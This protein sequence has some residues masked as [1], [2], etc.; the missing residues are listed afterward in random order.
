MET[1]PTGSKPAQSLAAND[2]AR[3]IARRVEEASVLLKKAQAEIAKEVFGQDDT[4]KT[5]L[6]CLVAGGHMLAEGVPGV[7]KTL[8]VSAMSKVIGIQFG[9]IQFTSDLMPGDIIGTELGRKDSAGNSY[10]EFVKGPLFCSFLLGDEINRA[11]PK[12]QSALLEAMQEK[13]VTTAGVT[14]R[15]PKPFHVMATQNPEDQEGTNPLPEAQIDRFMVCMDVDY[16]DEAASRRIIQDN[17][18]D[19][20][21]LNRLKEIFNSARLI[22]MQNLARKLPISK[23]VEDT[24][25]KIV[26]NARPGNND[27]IR[28]LVSQGPGP[29]ALKVFARMAQASALMD[30]RIAPSVDDVLKFVKP[31]LQHRVEMK[32]G[33][34][35]DEVK[36]IITLG[37]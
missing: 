11:S 22:E 33:K 24:I 30:G 9:R 15:L 35:F 26:F 29:R 28:D 19:E 31:V 12:T 32:Y 8:L 2:E 20:E 3:D 4:I 16:P 18:T 14:H 17:S 7:G 37:L 13:Q 1:E 10:L 6:A 23:K 34:S 25:I 5:A 27:A 36:K 21:K